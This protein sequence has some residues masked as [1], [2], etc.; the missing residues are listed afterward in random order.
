M[1]HDVI[2]F[3]PAPGTAHPHVQTVLAH[4]LRRKVPPPTVR[5]SLPTP[6]GDHVEVT[7]VRG[8]RGAPTIVIVHGLEGSPSSGYVVELLH[9]VVARGLGAAAIACRSCGRRS[10]RVV[11]S[12][13]AGETAD[14]A[15]VLA[16]LAGDPDVGPLGAVAVSLGGSLLLGHLVEA[17]DA[18]PLGAAVAISM[19]FDL[20]A[21]ARALD[22]GRGMTA[23]Y[24]R[25]FLASLHAK[26]AA[27]ALAYPGSAWADAPPPHAGLVAFDDRVVA[28]VH[29]F[30]GADDYYARCSAGPRLAAVRRPTLIVTSADDPLVPARS[31][32][33]DAIAA[34]PNLRGI[35]TA[36][37]GH[38]GFVAGTVARPRFWAE[39][40]AL[41]FLVRALAPG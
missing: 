37:G 39:E 6:D 19:P 14:L 5:V 8:P 31:Y 9:G 29:G 32:P 12:Y 1:L 17:G 24:R 26:A 7:R 25:R 3:V 38:A 10:H 30:A 36:H 4:V 33:A 11:R 28:R 34:N 20:D 21:A 13:H 18:S 40:T 35:L 2:P 16:H 41:D 15:L 23:I 22:G 27:R